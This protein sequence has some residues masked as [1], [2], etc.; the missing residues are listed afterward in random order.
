MITAE[1]ALERL[2]ALHDST[3][4]EA[5]HSEA[6]SVLCELLGALGHNDVVKAWEA[7]EKWFA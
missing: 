7:V 4:P 5:A 6:D 2:K 1:Q 3:D